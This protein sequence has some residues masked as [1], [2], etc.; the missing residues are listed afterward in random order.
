MDA[1]ALATAPWAASM[2]RYAYAGRTMIL[3]RGIL[4]IAKGNYHVYYRST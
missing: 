2:L 4:I 3:D 1:I